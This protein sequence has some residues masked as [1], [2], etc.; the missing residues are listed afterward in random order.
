M[1]KR[2]TGLESRLNGHLQA[3]DIEMVVRDPGML[4]DVLTEKK[5]S[6]MRLTDSAHTVEVGKLHAA[7]FACRVEVSAEGD[8]LRLAVT[9]ASTKTSKQTSFQESLGL[10]DDVDAVGRKVA[11][12]I[13][14][15]V[16][17]EYPKE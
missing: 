1:R 8:A 4:A 5:I 14:A 15:V 2:F 17:K 10:E 9:M 6:G 7:K 16:R 3:H 11:Y 12:K 13:A